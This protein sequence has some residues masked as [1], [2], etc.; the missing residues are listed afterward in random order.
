MLP[1]HYK[2]MFSLEQIQSGIQ[3]LKND[4]E[5]WAERIVAD[6][7]KD[8]LALCILRG[9]VFFYSDLLR[10]V[11]CSFE[12][13]F[14]QSWT[15]S[16]NSN[17]QIDSGKFFSM[18]RIDVKSR[19]ILLIDD[20][21]DTGTTLEYIH[22]EMLKRG[23]AEVQTAVLIHRI[24]EQTR[25]APTWSVFKHPG[26]EWFVGYGMEDRNRYSNLPAIYCLEMPTS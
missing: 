16:S 26:K 18:E 19:A 2:P 13:G 10:A 20:I 1:S 14:C 11:S 9:G 6:T 21:C 5:T 3:S 24:A 12:L 8:P 25:F 7:G 17:L 4:I 15:Y 22:S 23:A